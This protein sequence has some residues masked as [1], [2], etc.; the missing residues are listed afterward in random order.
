MPP[1]KKTSK[2]KG[3]GKGNSKG[4]S[5]FS[6]AAPQPISR[7]KL[8]RGREVIGVVEQRLGGGRTRI[9]CLD[10]V[11]RICV[12]PG[13]LKRQLWIREGDTV[14]VEPWEDSTDKGDILFKYTRNQVKFLQEKGHL[15]QIEDFEEF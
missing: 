8:P 4:K 11:S 13:R 3:K 6:T 10:G 14:I 1:Q 15:S 9:S 5:N 2:G 12:V 7:V